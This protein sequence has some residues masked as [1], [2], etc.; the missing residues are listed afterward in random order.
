[1]LLSKMEV[2]GECIGIKFELLKNIKIY[3]SQIDKHF[4]RHRESKTGKIKPPDKI[5]F[6]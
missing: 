5:Y 3:S 4:E 1:M 6:N 2:F